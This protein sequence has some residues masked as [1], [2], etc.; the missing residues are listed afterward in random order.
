[1]NGSHFKPTAGPDGL[2]VSRIVWIQLIGTLIAAAALLVLDLVVS[3]SVLLGGM[4]CVIPNA[5]LIQRFKSAANL[6]RD[7]VY[8]RLIAGEVGKLLFTAGLFVLVFTTVEPLNVLAFFGAL[9]S[10]Q[11]VHW[12]APVLLQINRVQ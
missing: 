7:K 6:E 11:F 3:Y 4:V 2:P 8:R 12:L 9:I 10:A 1:M 5:F